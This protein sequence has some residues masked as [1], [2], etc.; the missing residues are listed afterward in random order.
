MR[1]TVTEK[2]RKGAFSIGQ[3]PLMKDFPPVYHHVPVHHLSR[4]LGI[5]KAA[6]AL[7]TTNFIC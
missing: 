2:N 1:P 7:I 4:V 3:D 5:L 6:T